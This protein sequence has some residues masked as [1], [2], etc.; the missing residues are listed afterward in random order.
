MQG[1]CPKP[2]KMS[3]YEE[4]QLMKKPWSLKDDKLLAEL[5]QDVLSGTILAH[6]KTDGLFILMTNWSNV[7]F[8]AV[9]CQANPDHPDTPTLLEAIMSGEKCL[10]DLS[11]S[12]PHLHPISFIS[13]RPLM[14]IDK[15]A[16]QLTDYCKKMLLPAIFRC[17]TQINIFRLL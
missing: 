9:L 1:K 15:L 8:G 2:G 10:F 16:G 7:A 5:K 17:K 12:G 14:P 3:V 4:H 13:T 11:K 6:P